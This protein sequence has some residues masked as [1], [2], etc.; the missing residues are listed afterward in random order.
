[1]KDDESNSTE[2]HETEKEEPHNLVLRRLL[3]E[4]RQLE[5]YCPPNFH[6]NFSLFINDDDP[7]IVGEVVDSKDGK[8]W[9]KA[10]VEETTSLDKNEA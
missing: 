10:M 6:S 3:R 1:M 9:K 7:R 2:E 8:L 4:R 5:R